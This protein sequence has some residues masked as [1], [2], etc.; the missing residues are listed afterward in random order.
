MQT[1]AFVLSATLAIGSLAYGTARV[2]Q[3]ERAEFDYTSP[4]STLRALSAGPNATRISARLAQV[5]LA[6]GQHAVFELCASDGFAQERWRD[7]L[8]FAV[9]Q[10]ESKQLLLRVPFDAAHLAH[11]RR[12]S[13]GGCLLLARGPIETS[14]TYTVEAIW[15]DTPPSAAVLDVP[16]HVRVLAKAH[17]SWR[18]QDC[19]LA[20]GAA[21]IAIL[22]SSLIARRRGSPTPHASA[23]RRGVMLRALQATAALATLLVLSMVAAPGPSFT[24]AKGLMLLAVQAGLAFAGARTWSRTDAARALGLVAPS[25]R[26]LAVMSGVLAWPLLV[27]AARLALYWVP[28]TGEAPIETFIAWPSGMLAAALLGV[29]LPVGEEIFF[30]GYLYGALL[31][32]GRGVAACLSTLLFGAM[33]APQSWGNWGG[34]LAVFAAGAVLVGVRVLSGSTLVSSL[35]HVAYNLSLSA[36]SIAASI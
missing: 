7:A 8:A 32:F 16:L 9:L 20:L 35:T 4:P 14:G 33:H 26:T 34:L 13:Q 31:P 28:S 10:L 24:L 25:N 2:V 23:A 21:V 1:W 6:A 3:L 11:V 22:A 17:L 5:K 15:P 19:V 30:R 18:E 29:V 27:A 36:T 12:N